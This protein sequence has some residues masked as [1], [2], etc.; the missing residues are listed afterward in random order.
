MTIATPS[1][2]ATE[3]EAPTV[4]DRSTATPSA[5]EAPL[6]TDVPILL[7]QPVV[8]FVCDVLGA[9]A[10]FTSAAISL[11]MSDAVMV[12]LLVGLLVLASRVLRSFRAGHGIRAMM[13]WGGLASVPSLDGRS[14]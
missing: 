13:P 4:D 10:L 3:Y 6:S 14:N 9:M 7:D 5:S 11:S 8:R 2:R 1:P 12:T